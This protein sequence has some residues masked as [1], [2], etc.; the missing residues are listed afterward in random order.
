MTTCSIDHIVIM[1]DDLTAA[2]TSYRAL[3]FTVLEGGVHEFNPTHN[4]L[5]VFADGVYLEIIA[6]RPEATDVPSPRL[7]KWIQARSGL[8][9]FALLP[10]DIERDV[11]AARARGLL[12]AEDPQ[13]GGRALPDGQEIIWKTANLGA[14]G[15]PFLCADVTP[16]NLRVPDGEARQHPNGVVGVLDVIIG[17]AD[18]QTSLYSYRALLDLSPDI[19]IVVSPKVQQT[20]FPLG[21]ATLTLVQPLTETNP[22]QAY[23]TAGGPRPYR[24]T[25]RTNQPDQVGSLNLGQMHGAG[26]DLVA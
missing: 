23:L 5:I 22:L 24:L 25:L 18:V 3:G 15:L 14:G 26:I 7:Q 6:L 1:V 9:D 4:A 10:T 8:V 12:T 11:L 17:V 19:K 13:P 20:T 16:R 21:D 2:V